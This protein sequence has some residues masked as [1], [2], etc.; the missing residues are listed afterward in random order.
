MHNEKKVSPAECCSHVID[1]NLSLDETPDS[2]SIINVRQGSADSSD[3]ATAG[4]ADGGHQPRPTVCHNRHWSP[5]GGGPES[6]GLVK[7]TMV[8]H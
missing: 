7:Y 6:V 4:H 8:R 2:G 1:E 5:D 3:G